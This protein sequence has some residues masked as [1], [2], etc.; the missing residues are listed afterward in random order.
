[1]KLPVNG[2]EGCEGNSLEFD[3][4]NETITLRDGH[5]EPVGIV[6]W[7]A[8]ID[9]L[10]ASRN[11]SQAKNARTHSRA[12]LAIKVHYHTPEGKHF[13]SLTSGIGGGGLFIETS[14]PLPKG[15]ELEVEFLLPDNPWER[16]K[17]NATVSWVRRK[18]E[19]YVLPPGMGLTFI[20]ITPEARRKV[21]ELV[22]ALNRARER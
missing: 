13:E 5:D 7:E 3:R 19:R 4:D 15:T 8:M 17:A 1:M 18:T 12:R 10:Q 21:E 2:T 22:V 11:K 20:D 14:V 6:T 9:F 16:I